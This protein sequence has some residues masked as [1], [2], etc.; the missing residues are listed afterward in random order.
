MLVWRKQEDSFLSEHT[1]FP[2]EEVGV[3]KKKLF[4]VDSVTERHLFSD[5]CTCLYNQDI[6]LKKR[7]PKVPFL[8]DNGF[9]KAL[10]LVG[11]EF[12]VFYDHH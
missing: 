11:L 3:L 12:V 2:G 10:G 8:F 9:F 4:F 7:I 5:D 6:N 1:P